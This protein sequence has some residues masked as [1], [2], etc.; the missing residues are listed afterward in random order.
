[1]AAAFAQ[2]QCAE[3]DAKSG[4][5]LRAVESRWVAALDAG[6]QQLLACILAPEFKDIGVYGEPRDRDKVLADL[7]NRKGAGQRLDGLETLLFESTGIVRGVNHLTTRDGKAL[8]DV[9]F[10]D[11]FVYRDGR[12]QAVSAQESLVKLLQKR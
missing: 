8:V 12:W 7:P 5:G 4:D 2:Q 6:D 11:V 10:T 3:H 9:R 1:M